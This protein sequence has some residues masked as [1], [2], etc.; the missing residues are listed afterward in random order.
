MQSLEPMPEAAAT[1]LVEFADHLRLERGCS[2]HTVRAYLSDLTALFT[3]LDHLGELDLDR[4]SLADLR[5]WLANAHAAGLERATLQRR[6]ASV[7]TFF[8]WAQHSGRIATDPAASLRSPRVDRR[9]PPTLEIGQIRRVLDALAVAADAASEPD[10]IASARRDVALVEV[11]Y[12][13]GIR[14]SEVCGLD[15]G[16]VDPARG[17][18][19]VLGKGNKERIAPLGR[20]ALSAVEAWQQVRARLAG[21]TARRALFVGDRGGRIDPRVVRR[22]VHRALSSVPDA[23][24]LG[25]HGLRHAMA[26]HLLEGGADLRSVQ[27]M[28][29]HSSLAT[30]QLYTHVTTE[31]LRKAYRQAHPRA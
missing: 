25:P 4:V 8:A 9:L 12:S 24:D 15:T 1:L 13:S 16:D 18:L 23:P 30:T 22:I 28:L 26:T 27:E 19:R 14:V 29:G 5:T 7:R 20:P 17:L 2:P 21:P 6:A 11:L 10:Q 3:H 31:R